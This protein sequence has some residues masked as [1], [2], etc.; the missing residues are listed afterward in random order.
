M[1]TKLRKQFL[2]ADYMMEMYERFHMLRQNSMS[3]E[4]YTSEFNNLLIRVDSNESNEQVTSRYLSGLHQSIKD[5]IG[6][7]RLYYLEDAKQYALMAE[8]KVNRY[9]GR[10][11]NVW[12][13]E[14][15]IQKNIGA[16]RE[17]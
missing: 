17:F 15:S 12:R 14:D 10:K 16:A 8:K 7:V 2:P 6:V 3:V 13:S 1:K 11:P 5:E 4:E 9:G